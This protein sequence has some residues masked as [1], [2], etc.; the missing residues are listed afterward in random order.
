MKQKKMFFSKKLFHSFEGCSIF[1]WDI[2]TWTTCSLFI[3]Q[4]CS[5]G[6]NKWIID[7]KMRLTTTPSFNASK[8][9]VNWSKSNVTGYQL[10]MR[11]F[12][13]K[14]WTISQKVKHSF[15]VQGSRRFGSVN[16]KKIV[17]KTGGVS[18]TT[19]KWVMSSSTG[20]SK[21]ILFHLNPS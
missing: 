7:I 1:C 8:D 2:L 5:F 19:L 16:W 6:Q 17:P 15:S 10:I 21:T 18:Q 11:K 12:L 13:I 9:S 4:I 20:F 14:F 3:A